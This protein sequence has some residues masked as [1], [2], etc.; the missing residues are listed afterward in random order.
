M[1]VPHRPAV[2]IHNSRASWTPRVTRDGTYLFT[3]AFA[4]SEAPESLGYGDLREMVV[5]TTGARVTRANRVEKG[6]NQR[7][8]LTV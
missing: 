7:W 1:S 6:S 3:V 2:V 8:T 5:T 4:F